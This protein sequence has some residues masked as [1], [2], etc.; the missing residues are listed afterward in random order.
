M[1]NPLNV[2]VLMCSSCCNGTKLYL[3]MNTAAYTVLEHDNIHAAIRVKT[4]YPLKDAN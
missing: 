4:F 3:L 2:L 1:E